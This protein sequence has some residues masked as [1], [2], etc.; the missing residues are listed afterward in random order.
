MSRS[1]NRM[2][3]IGNL[4]IEPDVRTTPSGTPVGRLSVATTVT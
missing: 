2:T 4:G 3:L 1:L